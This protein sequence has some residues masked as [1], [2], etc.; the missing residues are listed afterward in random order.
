M[1]KTKR[2]GISGKKIVQLN[3]RSEHLFYPKP[4]FLPCSNLSVL[5]YTLFLSYSLSFYNNSFKNHQDPKSSKTKT[6]STCECSTSSA[7]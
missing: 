4:F 7:Y 2:R 5:R 6:E 1:H 3:K